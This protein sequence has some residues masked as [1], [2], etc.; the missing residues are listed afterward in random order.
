[1]M[2]GMQHD[3]HHLDDMDVNYV[4]EHESLRD[5]NIG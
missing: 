4:V 3:K 5:P 2:Y 1:M